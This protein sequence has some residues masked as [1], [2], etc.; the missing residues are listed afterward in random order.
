MNRHIFV[1]IELP[2]LIKEKI[3]LQLEKAKRELPFKQWVHSSDLHITLSFLGKTEPDRIHSLCQNLRRAVIDQEPF[4]LQLSGI[5]TFGRERAPRIF[6]GS[7]EHEPYLYSLQERVRQACKQSG[8]VLEERAYRP[9]ITFAKRWNSEKATFD[10]KWIENQ[11]LPLKGLS[12][13]VRHIVLYET[14]LNRTPKYEI[15]EKIC[16][17]GN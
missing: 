3:S 12:F 13:E 5:G 17:K 6:W 9:H 10:V 16:F 14:H 4:S 1:A 2:L 11:L 8:F 15:L 7:V